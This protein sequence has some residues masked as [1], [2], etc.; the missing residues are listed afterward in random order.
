MYYYEKTS[1]FKIFGFSEFA[2]ASKCRCIVI[3]KC[4]FN[5][6]VEIADSNTER[7]LWNDYL[8]DGNLWIFPHVLYE[9]YIPFACI[10][11]ISAHALS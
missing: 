10:V 8:E 6:T 9:M 5:P 1:N 11:N 7:I 4:D 3:D 2:L